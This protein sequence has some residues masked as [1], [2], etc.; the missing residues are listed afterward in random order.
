MD[1]DWVWLFLVGHIG[2]LSCNRMRVCGLLRVLAA[3]A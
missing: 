1:I 3:L 2:F